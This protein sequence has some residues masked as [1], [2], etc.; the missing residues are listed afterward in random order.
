MLSVGA[1]AAVSLNPALQA[2]LAANGA[3]LYLPSVSIAE[4]FSGIAKARRTG[5]IRRAKALE[6]WIGRILHLYEAR[7]L[8]FDG[9][10]ARITGALL[11]RA[12]ARGLA[13][14]LADLGIAGIAAAH[15][16]TVLTRNLRHFAPLDVP[17]LDPYASLPG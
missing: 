10:A 1:P 14:G 2:W 15:G 13:P 9:A 6:D 5:A 12:R 16:L 17:A 8:P 7:T 11:D 3:R 4:V